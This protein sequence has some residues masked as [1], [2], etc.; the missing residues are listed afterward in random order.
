MLFLTHFFGPSYKKNMSEYEH[1]K[2]G[3]K[4]DRKCAAAQFINLIPTFDDDGL[5]GEFY[6][7]FYHTWIVSE[8][9]GL[10]LAIVV[11]FVITLALAIF[12]KNGILI[13]LAFFS[14]T[15]CFLMSFMIYVYGYHKLFGQAYD[16]CLNR[17]INANH[18]L[19]NPFNAN[20]RP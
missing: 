7:N 11:I 19:D 2:D 13:S 9:S 6:K 15:W 10:N 1:Y 14:G 16:D 17:R 5:R 20:N 3:V 18:V 8:F 12:Y 4:L